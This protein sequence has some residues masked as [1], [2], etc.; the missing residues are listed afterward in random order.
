MDFTVSQVAD[1]LDLHVKTVRGYVREG[2]LKAVKVG[3]Q[4]RISR[5]DLESF[6]GA[7]LASRPRQD[8]YVEVSTIVQV[9]AISRLDMD[10]VSTAVLGSASGLRVEMIY[11]EERASLKMIILGGPGATADA[12]RM[13]EA[14]T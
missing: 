13:V 8:R 9:E 4:Y 3:K 12:L 10:R 14:L 6:T 5:E 11:N 1:L 2:R 7:P